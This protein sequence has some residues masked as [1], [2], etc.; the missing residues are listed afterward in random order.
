M[1]ETPRFHPSKDKTFDL[2][3][4]SLAVPFLSQSSGGIP[5]ERRC[6]QE[7][8][9][10]FQKSVDSI[11]CVPGFASNRHVFDLGGGQ[12]KI[13][14]DFIRKLIFDRKIGSIAD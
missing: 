3:S 13:C 4:L 12:G 7:V 11:L 10:G 5:V 6:R 14:Y 8:Y 2:Y 1:L 9:L